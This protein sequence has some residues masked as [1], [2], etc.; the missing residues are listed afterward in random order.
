[1]YDSDAIHTNKRLEDKLRH[2]FTL[3]RGARSDLTIRPEYFTLLERLGN[4]HHHVPPVIHVA[5]TNGKGSTMA[6]MRAILEAAGYKVHV[7]T[8]PHLVQFNERIVLAGEQISD[9]YLETLLDETM[10][11]NAGM[12]QTFFEITTALAFAAFAR[13]PADILLLETGLGGRLDSTNIIDRP[14]AT[15]I[16]TLSY[17]H[18]EFLGDTI[19][20]IAG[21]KAGIMKADTPCIVAHQIYPEAIAVLK[22]RAAV[23]N[24]PLYCE[25]DGWVM[26]G[27][28]EPGHDLFSV[29]T[30]VRSLKDLSTPS[31]TG[32]HQIRNAVT[33]CATLLTQTRFTIPANAFGEGLKNAFWPARLQKIDSP[34]LPSPE[35]ELWLDG[36]H[37][38]SAAE[39]LAEQAKRWAAGDG[40]PLYIIHGMMGHKDVG[41]FAGPL[42]HLT[43]AVICITLENGHSPEDLARFWLEAGAPMAQAAPQHW[44][45][46]LL[47]IFNTKL[48]G[49]IL[50]TGSLYLA[51]LVLAR[52]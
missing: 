26:D 38:D 10:E 51:Q 36:G 35:W 23:L 4:P 7:Y 44:P 15:V 30:R 1:M 31:L 33:A 24:A 27:S 11:K 3:K 28:P 25:N 19:D 50:L 18:M 40:K 32:V 17:D 43:S 45:A 22:A 20:S 39:A 9:D 14:L 37:N 2:I 12:E 34:L 47:E 16:T 41:S 29:H 46:P 13:V 5:G 48:P 21:E 6:F 49:R 52:A 8:S 42:A